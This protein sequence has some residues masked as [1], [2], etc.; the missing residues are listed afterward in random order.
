IKYSNH[1]YIIEIALNEVDV[2]HLETLRVDLECSHKICK[3]SN[4]GKL[5][6]FPSGNKYI[7][8]T[9]FKL[10]FN[11]KDICEDLISIF[12]ITPKK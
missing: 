10:R 4:S 1:G 6:K 12:N 2:E 3:M 8:G 7:C 5:K 11:S 9:T